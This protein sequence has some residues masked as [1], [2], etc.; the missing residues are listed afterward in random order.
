MQL[1][2]YFSWLGPAALRTALSE[3]DPL[4]FRCSIRIFFLLFSYWHV[5]SYTN[6]IEAGKSRTIWNNLWH[7]GLLVNF[8]TEPSFC[9]TLINWG[10][11][12]ADWLWL[13]HHLIRHPSLKSLPPLPV[14]STHIGLWFSIPKSLYVLLLHTCFDSR[15]NCLNIVYSA[16][17]LIGPGIGEW[18]FWYHCTLNSPSW[19]Y[20][21]L[22]YH[23]KWTEDTKGSA[24]L[25]VC[26]HVHMCVQVCT[27]MREKETGL[28]R[29]PGPR[30]SYWVQ[31]VRLLHRLG[32]RPPGSQRKVPFLDPLKLNC[33]HRPCNLETQLLIYQHTNYIRYALSHCRSFE[34]L[35]CEAGKPL[36]CEITV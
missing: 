13:S 20:W 2:W 24:S 7:W 17:T 1:R 34:R 4:L 21:P 8:T 33:S 3:S 28:F 15:D 14:C 25:N 23:F 27:S 6:H 5:L 29:R 12:K 31:T 9:S 11:R 22:V 18:H 10:H 30:S 32:P 36:A 19:L 16:C 26:A 35:H